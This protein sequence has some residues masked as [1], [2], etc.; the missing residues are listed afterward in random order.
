MNTGSH[1]TTTQNARRHEAAGRSTA[2][3]PHHENDDFPPIL[4]F[5]GIEWVLISIIVICLTA[6]H[7]V[8]RREDAANFTRTQHMQQPNKNE[9]TVPDGF[10]PLTSHGGEHEQHYFTP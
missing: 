4:R 8:N 9:Q 7:Q 1:I 10:G 6:L 3:I 5:P 2:P